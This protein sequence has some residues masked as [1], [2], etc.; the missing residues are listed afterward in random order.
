VRFFGALKEF[1][2]VEKIEK[3][4]RLV[5]KFRKNRM[6]NLKKAHMKNVWKKHMK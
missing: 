6:K 5:G 3:V 4:D 2:N 1:F